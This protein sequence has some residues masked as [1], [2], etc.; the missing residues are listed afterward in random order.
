MLIRRLG[1]PLLSVLLLAGCAASPTN[2]APPVA[3]ERIA[4][5]AAAPPLV[6]AISMDGLNPNAIRK[7]GGAAP[8]YRRL[9]RQGSWT[10]NARAS[11]ELT[12]TL[13][14]HTSMMTGRPIKGRSGH[15]VTFNN[16][17]PSTW[18]ARVAGRYVRGMFDVTH[19]RAMRT[20]LYT[21]KPKF[22][23]L[24]RSW[25]GRHGA[26]D[27][28]GANNGRDKIGIYVRTSPGDVVTRMINRLVSRRPARV[29]FWHNSVPDAAGH[30]Y[31]FMS[32]RYVEA[33]RRTDRMLGRLLTA[34]DR[35]P[36]LKRRVTIILTA[37]H[38][39]IG[40]SHRDPTR[41]ANYR[42]PFMVWG[43]GVAAG[44]DLYA[45]NPARRNP[46]T[47]RTGYSGVQPIRNADVAN[48]AATLVGAP[49]VY[50]VANRPTIRI[51]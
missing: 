31:G 24:N 32:S 18:L 38:G 47:A 3:H 22:D 51:R 34:L 29:T 16:D 7:L 4:L 14:N 36:A 10:F 19:D 39:G 5:A 20:A 28:V 26:I 6:I 46:G 44:R 43:R 40:A 9:M 30:R 23:F 48:L 8:H 49:R 33:V 2:Q 42:I 21:S 12:D 25:N 17:R 37:D 13:P 35:R 11:N 27:R 50:A 15:R 1:I 41:L 45:L